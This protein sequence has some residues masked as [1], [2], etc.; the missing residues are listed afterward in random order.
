[1][2]EFDK[3]CGQ[4]GK[5]TGTVLVDG[6]AYK[7]HRPDLYFE[8]CNVCEL[9]DLIH[10]CEESLREGGD[11]PHQCWLMVKDDMCFRK[12]DGQYEKEEDGR[13]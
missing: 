2:K 9:C 4:D 5:W 10:H 12:V 8:D 11:M 13:R 7:A 1:M 6:E 3:I